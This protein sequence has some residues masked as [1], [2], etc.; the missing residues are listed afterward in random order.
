[1]IGKLDYKLV[2]VRLL[3]LYTISSSA[4]AY[5]WPSAPLLS[6]IVNSLGV[7]PVLPSRVYIPIRKQ[8]G[9]ELVAVGGAASLAQRAQ[10]YLEVSL[11]PR[12]TAT[13]LGS[14]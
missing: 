14:N 13:K 12:Y 7:Y 2:D 4:I 3:D 6:K 9:N 11:A 1:M 5:T 10:W 8:S